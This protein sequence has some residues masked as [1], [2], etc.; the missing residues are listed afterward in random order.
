M[1]APRPRKKNVYLQDGKP[2]VVR[3]PH[4]N[5][6]YLQQ[7]V[8]TAFEMLGGLE[9]TLHSG[10]S[11][12]IKPNFNCAYATPLSTDLGILTAVI[13]V[14]QDH[15][16]K[17][18]VGELSGRAAWPTEKVVADLGVLPVLKRYGV[19][20]VNFQYDEWVEVD[21]PGKYWQKIHVP[22]SIYEAEHRLNL[23]NMRC[24]SSGRF[25]CSLKLGV[26]FISAEDR[27]IMH[28]DRTTT[29]AMIAELNL[30]FQPDLI[31]VDG[32]RTTVEWAG[33]GAY[34]YPNLILASGD[35]VAVDSE[36]VKILKGYPAQNRIQIPLEELPQL[37]VAQE[38][39]LGSMDYN[40]IEAP[41]HTQTEES[42][43]RD[44]A[45]IAVM[46]VR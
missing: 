26:G 5:G 21:I 37:A 32:R 13:E 25:S 23:S 34:V 31:L 6:E 19:P 17:V 45:T 20:F 22:R 18:T 9:K 36:V 15:G 27:E 11:I 42:D 46:G 2:L 44:P 14:L 12:F 10:D 4:F 39:G 16:V 3:V 38:H 41:A 33:R 40:V 7:S 28:A 24:H 29:E 35:M 8:R 30:A 43:N 1:V